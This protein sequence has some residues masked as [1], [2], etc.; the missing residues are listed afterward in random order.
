MS[1]SKTEIGPPRCRGLVFDGDA[2]LMVRFNHPEDGDH[3]QIPGGGADPGETLGECLIRELR[4][5]TGLIVEPG[6]L[7]YLS[8]VL[9]GNRV[10]PHMYFEAKA[11]GGNLQDLSAMTSEESEWFVERRFVNRSESLAIPS[12]PQHGVWDRVWDDRKRG[13]PEPVYLGA[14]TWTGERLPQLR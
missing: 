4:E 13:F 9:A 12:H 8:H 1:N 11:V 14:Y 7:R 5:E 3:W 10:N 6:E 2:L